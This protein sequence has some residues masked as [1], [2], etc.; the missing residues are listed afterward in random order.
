MKRALIIKELREC[1]PL[2]ALAALLAAGT[3][4][5]WTGGTLWP[6]VTYAAARIP[7]VGDDFT[8]G[9]LLLIAGGLAIVLGLKQSGWEELRGTYHYLLHRP[10]ER[11]QVFL[12]KA[13]VG[14]G[15][16]LT[17]GAAMILIYALWAATPGTHPS[18]F[19][20]SMTLPAWRVWATLPAVYL[21]A[22]VWGI[23]PA[24]SYRSG[25]F[26][27]LGCGL[28]VFV[29]FVQPWLWIAVLGGL[30]LAAIC[31]AVAIDQ[32]RTRDY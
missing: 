32:A 21:A 10:I 13:V 14:L 29:L 22:L 2:A 6:G 15:I 9:P 7:F 11:R 23:R 5:A 26:P 4:Y 24:R 25:L 28:V 16:V 27:P 30:V 31:W 18:P 3:L 8:Y 19:F 1:A 20:W 12:L 17:L